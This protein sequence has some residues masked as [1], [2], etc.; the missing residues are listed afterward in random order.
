M[1]KVQIKSEKIT[2]FGGIFHVRELFSRFVAPIIDKVLGIRCTS[3]GYQY[4]EIV[5]SLASVYFC[6][7]DCVED[8]TSHLMSHLS[9]H[10]TLRTCS[11]DTI[12][13]AISELAVGNT[14]YTSD[15]GR[16]YDF[17]TA[18]MLNSLLVKALLSTGQLVAVIGELIVGIENRDGNANVRFHQQDTLER[19]FSNLELNGIHIRRARMD[20]GSCSREIVETIE[21]HSE[22]FYIRANRCASLY[23]SLLALRGWKKEE[24]NGIEYELN[25]ITVEKWEGKAYRLVIQRER[26]TDGERDLWEGE[27]TYR[28]I[29]TNDYTSTNREIVEFYNLRG[30]KER[31]LDDMNNGFGWARLPKSFMA[32]NTVFL[33]LTALIRNF[34]KFLMDRLDTKAFG[35]KRNSRIKAF[36]FKFIS[37]PAKWIRTARRYELNIYTDNKSYLNPFA[38]ADG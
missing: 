21:R 9:L 3:F 22:H 24:I 29:L 13:R 2:P 15:T 17:N 31:I 38:L 10:P 1:A 35:L 19:I 30:G 11:S 16:S 8:V 18:T 23:D 26:R 7:G 28:C 27:Y 12:L 33:L 36:V 37:V 4:S 20:C 25:S 5:G 14:T 32:E 34:Y 6:G